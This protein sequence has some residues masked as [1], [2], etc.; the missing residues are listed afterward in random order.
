MHISFAN[1][2]Y[3]SRD[4]VPEE[5]A[6]EERAIFEKLAMAG[7]PEDVRPKIVEGMLPRFFAET[8]PHGSGLDPR[9]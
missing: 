1:P 9:P 8:V 2:T 4:E 5:A 3:V 6:D 7:K